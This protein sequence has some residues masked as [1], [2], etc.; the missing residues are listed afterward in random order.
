MYASYC[1]QAKIT[2]NPSTR[3]EAKAECEQVD[4]DLASLHTA[5]EN[6]LATSLLENGGWINGVWA[7]VWIWD[8]GTPWDFSNIVSDDVEDEK[9]LQMSSDGKWI[10][11]DCKKRQRRFLCKMKAK[12]RS[13]YERL[14][15]RGNFQIV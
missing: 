12:L 7:A 2:N 6:E 13:S 14:E 11:T 9:C 10:P 15:N 4:S 1:F 3:E 5:Q 8:D